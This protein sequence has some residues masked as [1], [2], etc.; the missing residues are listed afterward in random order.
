MSIPRL[1]TRLNSKADNEEK[2]EISCL[3]TVDRRNGLDDH[4][5]GLALRPLL[6]PMAESLLCSRTIKTTS[7]S[8]NSLQQLPQHH[9]EL[10][11]IN[12]GLSR[13]QT[14]LCRTDETRPF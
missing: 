13:L 8:S 6:D 5:S 1:I 2:L 9:I 12:P 4:V 14:P 7:S 11:E 10:N 3:T